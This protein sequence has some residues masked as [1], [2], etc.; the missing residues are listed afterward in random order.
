MQSDIK[1]L[2]K[3]QAM[4]TAAIL[5]G[6]VCLTLSYAKNFVM[7]RWALSRDNVACIPAESEH[8]FPIVYRQ[9]ADHPVENDALIKSFVDAYIH[10]TLNEQIVDYHAPS[11]ATRYKDAMLSKAKWA[12]IEMSTGLERSLNMKRYEESS[13]VFYTLKK[14]NVGWIFLVDDIMIKGIPESGTVYAVVRGEFQVTYDKVK[15]DLPNKLWGY[16]EIHLLV[17]QGIPSGNMENG[18]Y[19]NKYGWYVTWSANNTLTPDQKDK[20]GNRT[21]DFY[22]MKD[23]K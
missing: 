23:N 15:S 18:Q 13:E 2:K 11:G 6:V 1:F 8:S 10:L 16:R 9:S 22:M 14:A 4:M 7:E 20:L 21:A 12:A 3:S 17:N 19:N 5:C